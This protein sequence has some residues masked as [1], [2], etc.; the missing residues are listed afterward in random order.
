MLALEW[1]R[2]EYQPLTRSEYIRIAADLIERTPPHI[3]FHRLTGTAS[4]DILLAPAWCSEKWNVLNGIELELARR[5]RR[6]G[7]RYV[8]QKEILHAA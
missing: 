1:K 4:Q 5:G 6:Q 2:G 8:E 3:V 7:D